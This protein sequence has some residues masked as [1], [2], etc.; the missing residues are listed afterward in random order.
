MTA[1]T[2]LPIGDEI[3]AIRK[4]L[5]GIGCTVEDIVKQILLGCV[6]DPMDIAY[7]IRSLLSDKASFITGVNLVVDG[8]RTADGG[9]R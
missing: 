9:K 4:G 7:S 2:K 5:Q 3:H 8:G 6:G 1:S